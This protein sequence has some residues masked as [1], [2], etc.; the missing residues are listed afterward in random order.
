MDGRDVRRGRRRELRRQLADQPFVDE[1]LQ[2]RRALVVLFEEAPAKRVDKEQDHRVILLIEI[3][4][5]AEGHA[6]TL[7]A[8]E[9]GADG[10]WNLREPVAVVERAH[11]LRSEPGCV[12]G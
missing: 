5:R 11:E 7:I 4:A 1:A 9:A 3:V 8:G 2:E 10:L 6:L 12:D